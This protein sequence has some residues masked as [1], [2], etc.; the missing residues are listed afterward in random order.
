[1]DGG[2]TLFYTT[3]L[4]V[5]LGF[6]LFVGRWTTE[7]GVDYKY[8]FSFTVRFELGHIYILGSETA[9]VVERGSGVVLL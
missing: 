1:L 5:S 4:D 2:S 7:M 8:S 6:N 3:R 9:I